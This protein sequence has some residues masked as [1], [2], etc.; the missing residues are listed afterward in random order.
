MCMWPRHW[1]SVQNFWRN[2]AALSTCH[3]SWHSI[4]TF[5]QFHDALN[6]LGISGYN[7]QS[8][9]DYNRRGRTR[10]YVLILKMQKR[11]H[12]IICVH[13]GD[14][15]QHGRPNQS[16]FAMNCMVKITVSHS[17]TLAYT[18]QFCRF[19]KKLWVRGCYLEHSKIFAHYP[20]SNGLAAAEDVIAETL[21]VQTNAK[22][23]KE[24]IKNKFGKCITLNNVSNLKAKI[25]E[26]TVKG[27]EEPR[28]L[29]T[30]LNI[31]AQDAQAC[32]VVKEDMKNCCFFKKFYL[33]SY[34]KQCT[35]YHLNIRTYLKAHSKLRPFTIKGCRWVWQ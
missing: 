7:S 15:R 24:L 26:H 11:Y 35:Q 29:L 32:I 17:T 27:V 9:E 20:I 18:N 6:N 10:R 8:G 21:T 22:R 28:V 14:T 12:S 34:C 13:Y 1:R 3:G 19:Y 2:S 31:T 33:H 23:V 4:D 5:Q 25:K 16:S 30:T